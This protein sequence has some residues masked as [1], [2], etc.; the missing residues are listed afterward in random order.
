MF[1]Y[2]ALARRTNKRRKIVSSCWPEY[3]MVSPELLLVGAN[4]NDRL[5]Q[6]SERLNCRREPC[7]VTVENSVL[8]RRP[9]RTKLLVILLALAAAAHADTWNKR[10]AVTGEPRLYV[11]AGDG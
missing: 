9:M 4:A 2:S 11:K 8:R 3:L 1:F 7:V 10:Y 6:A 5:R